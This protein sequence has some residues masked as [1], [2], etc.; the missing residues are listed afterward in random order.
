[1]NI[2]QMV[3]QLTAQKNRLDVAISALQACNGT[4]RGRPRKISLPEF[5]YHRGQEFERPRKKKRHMSP[6]GRLAIQKAIQKMWKRRRAEA[7]AKK[8]K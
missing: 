1:M 8:T 3:L 7:K 4:R 6:E 5:D 2:E